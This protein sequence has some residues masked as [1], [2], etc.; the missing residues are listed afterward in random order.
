MGTRGEA[1][2]QKAYREFKEYLVIV[3]YLWV[4][5]GLFLLYKSVILNEQHFSYVA[6][7]IALIDALVL[8]KFILIARAFH[9]GDTAEDAPLIYPTLLKSALFSILLAGCKVL[10]DAAA[11]FFHGKSFSQ[12]IAG[13]GGGTLKGILT[14]TMLMF[15]MFI[16]FFGFG[17]LERVLGEHKLA[18]LFLRPRDVPEPTNALISPKIGK[19]K[20]NLWLK[21]R[22][23]KKKAVQV[24]LARLKDQIQLWLQET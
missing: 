3:L 5:F 18:Q 22:K 10:E 17:E 8:G 7:G 15:V 11:G 19:R 1:L 21:T 14:L 20:E 16:P 23:I 13:L 4:V 12:S 24:T 6:R 9:L 2:K